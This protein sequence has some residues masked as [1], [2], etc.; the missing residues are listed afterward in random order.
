[1]A[2]DAGLS[3]IAC[4]TAWID[5]RRTE[6]LCP[7]HNAVTPVDELLEH[8]LV[9]AI[10]SDNIHDIYKPF[11]TGDMR[12]EIKFLLESLHIYDI[13]TLVNIST[14]NGLKVVGL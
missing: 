1:M 11:S 2:K 5:A 12:T 7:I 8:D 6:E 4:P 3:F 10:G 13:E 14:R 9:V